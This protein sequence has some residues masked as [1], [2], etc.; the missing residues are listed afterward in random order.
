M[1]FLNSIILAF[2]DYGVVDDEGVPSTESWRNALVETTG[3]WFTVVFTI[4]CMIKV[5]GMGFVWG[6]GAYLRDAWNILDFVV[7]VA[8]VVE[9]VFPDA[10]NV[11]ILRTF[12]V[13]RPL[14]SLS[15]LPGLR[16]L[17]VSLLASIPDLANVVLLL[18]FTLLIFGILGMQLWMGTMHAR[19]R[20]FPHPVLVPQATMWPTNNIGST[21]GHN[22]AGIS[23]FADVADMN[24]DAQRGAWLGHVMSLAQEDGVWKDDLGGFRCL[25]DTANDD[26]TWTQ[27]SSPWSEPQPCIWPLLDPDD[28]RICTGLSNSNGNYHCPQYIFPELQRDSPNYDKAGRAICG[29]NFDLLGNPRFL[30]WSIMQSVFAGVFTGDL[31]WGYTNFDHMGGAFLTIF[32]AVTMEGWVDIMYQLQDV[33]GS[34]SVGIVFIM[35][36]VFGSFVVLN[37]VLAVL[38][39]SLDANEEEEEEEDTAAAIAS[40]AADCPQDGS[41]APEGDSIR[42]V[43]VQ[44]EEQLTAARKGIMHSKVAS[45]TGL[46]NNKHF[47]AFIIFLIL[48]NTVVLAMDHH[49]MT[50]AF[51]HNL[52]LVNFALTVC[53]TIEMCIKM[54]GL[55]LF[56]YSEDQFNLFDCFIVLVSWVEFISIPPFFISGKN[57][58]GGCHLGSAHLQALSSVQTRARLARHEDPARNHRQDSARHRELRGAAA[59][60]HV[61]LFSRRDAVLGQQDALPRRDSEGRPVRRLP[62]HAQSRP[63]RRHLRL[64]FP[65]RAAPRTLRHDDMGADHDLP[66]A[67]RR[68]LEH[69][70]VR[71]LESHWVGRGDLLPAPRDH[72][73]LHRDEPLHG[74]PAAALRG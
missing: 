55:G 15:S 19:C 56:T 21:S 26:D 4:E 65:H 8:G 42:R 45:L 72:R 22:V 10:P 63:C 32:Q 54:L 33:H 30:D 25:L 1:I 67:Q 13:L 31:N 14:R 16:L 40:D 49:P 12:R 18:M 68:E 60:L 7:V 39:E 3:Y 20:S 9:V 48:A 46:A 23:Q 70:D 17:I 69:G 35:L 58:G 59:A 38:C 5:I 62:Q 52:E 51:A 71:Q 43:S 6:R 53:F 36:I 24:D 64:R 73:Q 11:S 50:E 57:G 37:L 2:V 29:S 44:I 74:H 66:G 34:T 61:H 27:S 28:G 41:G 47:S